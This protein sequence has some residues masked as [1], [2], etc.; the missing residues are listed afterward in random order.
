MR[1]HITIICF[2]LKDYPVEMLSSLETTN[3]FDGIKATSCE[4]QPNVD[5][6]EDGQC[7]VE[8]VDAK[9]SLSLDDKI[10]EANCQKKCGMYSKLFCMKF[11]KVA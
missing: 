10:Q 9:V 5:S 11:S 3:V 8:N 6:N 7:Q 4:V 1:I 2:S